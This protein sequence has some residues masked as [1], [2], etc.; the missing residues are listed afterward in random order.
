MEHESEELK[1][2]DCAAAW[3][4]ARVRWEKNLE[5]QEDLEISGAR[6]FG[7][8]CSRGQATGAADDGKRFAALDVVFSLASRREEY[9]I[10]V[11]FRGG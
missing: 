2:E 4:D 8:P 5:S 1:V 11:G 7:T 10:W 6:A 9:G 3:R